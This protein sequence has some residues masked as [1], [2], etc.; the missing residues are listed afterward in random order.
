MSISIAASLNMTSWLA[1]A[2][3]AAT[4]SAVDP[5]VAPTTAPV[6]SSPVLVVLFLLWIIASAI[7]IF[8]AVFVRP[9]SV[10]GPTRI[11]DRQQIGLLIISFALGLMTWLI[12]Q[13]AYESYMLAALKRAGV[14]DAVQHFQEYLKPRDLAVLGTAPFI[15][16]FVVMC[17]ALTLSPGRLIDRLGLRLRSIG[18]GV[19]VGCVAFLVIFPGVMVASAGLEKFYN[20]VGYAHPAE[21]DVLKDLGQTTQRGVAVLLVLGATLCAPLF[22]EVLFRGHVQTL[23]RRFFMQCSAWYWPKETA[24]LQPKPWHSWTAIVITS[25]L[26]AM[27]HPPWMAPLIFILALGLGYIYERTGILW[28]SITVHLLFNS[29]ETLQYYWFFMRGH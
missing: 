7:T 1:D 14:T 17:T 8:R 21:H 23:L 29:V 26:F 12:S 9:A 11:E 25:A 28:A 20:H 22:E 19:A 13:A 5:V 15:I 6:G 2:I 4:Q 18:R 16:G 10:V 27:V 3:H 24:P